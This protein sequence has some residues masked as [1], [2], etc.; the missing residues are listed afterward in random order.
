MPPEQHGCIFRQAQPCSNKSTVTVLTALPDRRWPSATSRPSQGDEQP[1]PACPT[2][3]PRTA[4]GSTRRRA[5]PASILGVDTH[6]DVHVA[7]VVT[8]L[9]AQLADATFATTTA[10]Y[11]QLLA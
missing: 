8:T 4:A 10:G 2:P 9:G 5:R 1:C 11:R 6:A 7:A 3:F